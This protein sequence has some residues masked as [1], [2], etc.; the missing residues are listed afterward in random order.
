MTV[1]RLLSYKSPA[2]GIEGAFYKGVASTISG[3]TP[4]GTSI[5]HTYG[6]FWNAAPWNVLG[7]MWDLEC[8]NRAFGSTGGGLLGSKID[9]N[10]ELFF[11]PYPENRRLIRLRGAPGALITQFDAGFPQVGELYWGL[12]GTYSTNGIPG[13]R[14]LGFRSTILGE[15][16]ANWHAIATDSV[17]GSPVLLDED[18]GVAPVPAVLSGLRIDLDGIA[19]VIRFYMNEVLLYT[20][21]PPSGVLGGVATTGSI[22]C[23]PCMTVGFDSGASN[24]IT[25][26]FSESLIT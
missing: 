6:V 15:T 7:R 19:G 5:S 1:E 9:F 21:T 17:V 23:G 4:G 3:G 26:V 25:A 16:F 2:S 10:P 18:L 8:Y 12:F 14:W 13:H 11:P 20:W 22:Y 24:A